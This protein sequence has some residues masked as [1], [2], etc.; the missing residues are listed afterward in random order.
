MQL[1]FQRVYLWAVEMSDIYEKLGQP[2]SWDLGDGIIET[3]F[4]K[5]ASVFK[6]LAMCQ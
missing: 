6:V 1:C 3:G 4:Y 5:D 2:G